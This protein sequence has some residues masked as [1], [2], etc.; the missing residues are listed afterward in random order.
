M[1]NWLDK[2]WASVLVITLSVLLVYIAFPVETGQEVD[3]QFLLRA[4][5]ETEG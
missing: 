4:I 2:H 3:L 5:F 1:L